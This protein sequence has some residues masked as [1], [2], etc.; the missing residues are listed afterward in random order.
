[1]KI[2]VLV[3]ISFLTA[4][5]ASALVHDV[6][7]SGLK[8]VPE[9]LSVTQGD[10]VRWTNHD[11]VTHTSTSGKPDSAQGVLWDS[12]FLTNGQSWSLPITFAGTG[13]PYHCRIHFLTMKGW[14]N[15][16]SGVE[17]QPGKSE[18]GLRLALRS[19]NPDAVSFELSSRQRVSLRIY[20][21][22]GQ[23][24][25]APLHDVL[26]DPGPHRLSL[27]GLG[28]KNGFYIVSLSA[29]ASERTARMV[30]L[31]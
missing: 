7:M 4:G 17:E 20:D 10:T 19:L 3:A 21:A 9:T 28:L 8:F 24:K 22:I 12:P 14:L 30:V 1:M 16:S 27:A 11:A 29:G 15:V 18:P 31:D 23:E 5:L 25:A 26:F 13:I 6:S 2:K